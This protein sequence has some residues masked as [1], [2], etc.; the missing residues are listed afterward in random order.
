MHK[1]GRGALTTEPIS[2]AMVEA[3][4]PRVTALIPAFNEA[5]CIA[6]TIRSLQAQTVPLARIIVVDDCSTDRTGGCA[7]SAGAFVVQLSTNGGKAAAHNAGLAF[8]RT[9][10]VLTVDADTQLAPDALEKLF[11]HMNNPRVGCACASVLPQGQETLWERGRFIE[12]ILGQ[13]IHK[14]A[15]HVLCSVL[16]AAGCCALY[17]TTALRD[18]GG[19]R[20]DTMTEDMDMAWQLYERGLLTAFEPQ[21]KCSTMEPK[22]KHT[23]LRQLDRW[24]RGAFQVMALHRFRHVWKLKAL[25]YWYAF[26]AILAPAWLFALL[27]WGTSA[28]WRSLGAAVCIDLGIAGF[29]AMCAEPG[30]KM[31]ILRCLPA[32]LVVRQLNTYAYARAFWL[33]HVRKQ[34]LQTWNKGH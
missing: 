8:V 28:P 16:V 1:L 6:A 21:A 15:Q 12:Y 23:Y 5:A 32:Y 24:Y 33:E 4:M 27:Y 22:T 10:Y 31:E 29:I 3:I 9:P 25:A 7:R 19:F 30:R 20:N 2:A 34:R 13:T 18:V 17:K 26:D 14:Q 11:P